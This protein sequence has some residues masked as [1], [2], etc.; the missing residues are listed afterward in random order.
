MMKAKDVQ[1]FLLIHER[2]PFSMLPPP[3][4]IITTALAPFH[5]GYIYLSTKK[6]EFDK[7]IK[8]RNYRSRVSLRRNLNPKARD[9]KRSDNDEDES[10]GGTNKKRC[11]KEIT[12]IAG[13]VGDMIMR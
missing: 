10:G 3:L 12:S 1:E 4:N 9:E 7:M 2:S 6:L 5:Y 8:D 13:T 11:R